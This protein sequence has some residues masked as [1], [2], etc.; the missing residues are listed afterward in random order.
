M[1]RYDLHWAVRQPIAFSNSE[2]SWGSLSQ[3]LKKYGFISNAIFKTCMHAHKSLSNK[4][5]FKIAELEIRL[6]AWRQGESLV[7]IVDSVFEQSLVNDSCVNTA[8]IYR[9][10]IEDRLAALW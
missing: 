3:L 6:C 9:G 1:L 8:Y 7:S 4:T 5:I 10:S 2:V